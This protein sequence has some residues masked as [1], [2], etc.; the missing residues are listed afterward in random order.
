MTDPPVLRWS[1]TIRALFSKRLEPTC[2][3]TVE[4]YDKTENTRDNFAHKLTREN[5]MWCEVFGSCAEMPTLPLGHMLSLRHV[6]DSAPSP[7]G[8]CGLDNKTEKVYERES[9]LKYNDPV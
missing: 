5:N 7:T 4:E 2:E 9:R 3:Y 8:F 1:T 6:F